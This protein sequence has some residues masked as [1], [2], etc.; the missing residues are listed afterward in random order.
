MLQDIRNQKLYLTQTMSA[1]L[2]MKFPVFFLGLL[3]S[4]QHSARCTAHGQEV[5]LTILSIIA[6]NYALTLHV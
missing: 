4:D 6:V 5:R 2:K 1:W 3:P